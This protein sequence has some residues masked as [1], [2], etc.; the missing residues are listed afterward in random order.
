[1]YDI[2][3]VGC[4]KLNHR[5]SFIRSN[6]EEIRHDSSKKIFYEHYVVVVDDKGKIQTYY[7]STI[8]TNR[9]HLDLKRTF[10]FQQ[11]KIIGC[12]TIRSNTMATVNS[13][14]EDVDSG[15]AVLIWYLFIFQNQLFFQ[16]H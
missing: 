8:D 1:M 4:I 10:D 6:F 5:V 7:P 11:T 14:T 16:G 15:L 12:S 2:K 13:S 3:Q 9:W